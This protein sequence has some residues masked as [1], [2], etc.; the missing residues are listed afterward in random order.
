MVLGVVQWQSGG[1]PGELEWCQLRCVGQS[2]SSRD[3]SPDNYWR[4]N[5]A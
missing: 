1:G 2:G 5:L 3:D 4:P